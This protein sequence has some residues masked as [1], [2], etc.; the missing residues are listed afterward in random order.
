MWAGVYS[1]AFGFCRGWCFRGWCHPLTTD[2]TAIR[3]WLPIE[4][5][6]R[7]PTHT[8]AHAFFYFY[9]SS[10]HDMCQVLWPRAHSFDDDLMWEPTTQTHTTP[11]RP[12]R[13]GNCTRVGMLQTKCCCPNRI[14]IAK[15]VTK[16][17]AVLHKTFSH[18]QLSSV[19]QYA[20]TAVHQS[21]QH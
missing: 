9:F 3:L 2:S 20:T 18:I 14:K 7:T 17:T 12:A 21:L 6:Y 1:R 19:Y 13:R 4:R 15:H 5:T 16:W 10:Q 8:H 11:A